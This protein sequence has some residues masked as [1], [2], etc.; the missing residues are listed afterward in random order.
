MRKANE[1]LRVDEEE[2][3]VQF[4]EKGYLFL[5]ST[6]S[7][8]R[9]MRENYEVQVGQGAGVKL[10]DGGMLKEKFPWLNTEDIVLGSFGGE[11]MRE[12]LFAADVVLIDEY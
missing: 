7:G 12:H 2:V 3:D 6:E 11:W 4:Q 5:A 10:F 1:L 8:A 9:V